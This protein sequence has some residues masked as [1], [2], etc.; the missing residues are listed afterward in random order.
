M[1]RPR[2]ALTKAREA[3]PLPEVWLGDQPPAQ[4][5][6][7]LRGPSSRKTEPPKTGPPRAKRTCHGANPFVAV[8]FPGR[9][10]GRPASVGRGKIV[11]FRQRQFQAR[12]SRGQR[13]D[14]R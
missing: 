4:T 6:Q 12:H 8:S 14:D 2:T 13:G 5:L 3:T 9:V 7:T 1:V 11:G 10:V